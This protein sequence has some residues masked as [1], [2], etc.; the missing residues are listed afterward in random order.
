MPGPD[1]LKPSPE[2]V[3][4]EGVRTL[5][6]API[7][8]A[9][10]LVA[11]AALLVAGCGH[12]RAPPE[13]APPGPEASA[14]ER[15][16]G[17]AAALPDVVGA[18]LEAARAALVA[19]GTAGV[20]VLAFDPDGAVTAQQP[21]AGAPVEDDA[22][23][24][25]W[26]GDPPAPPP[27]PPTDEPATAAA[28][29]AGDAQEADPEPPSAADRDPGFTPDPGPTP[30]P[31]ATP[32]PG[33]PSTPPAEREAAGGRGGGEAGTPVR[34]SP[35]VLP[36]SPAGLTLEGTASWYGPG[37]EGLSTA[38]GDRF[39]PDE[40]TLATRELRCGTRVAL[41]GP[42]GAVVEAV[43]TDWGPAEWT[44]RRFD[45]SRATFEALAPLSRGTVEVTLRVLD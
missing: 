11:A 32:D 19:A 41:T 10:L 42:S 25:V 6:L 26:L 5:P 27:A 18:D 4:G 37:F 33:P 2:T 36:A 39:D 21:P 23:V 16:S 38:C 20:R 29:D 7:A 22:P 8:T 24:L 1:D 45:L 15:D 34:T 44:G 35:R 17:T 12:D 9:A 43:A 28:P 13:V 14:Q 31:G 30:D 3:D 40:R